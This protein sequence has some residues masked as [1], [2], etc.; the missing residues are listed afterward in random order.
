MSDFRGVWIDLFKTDPSD[1]EIAAFQ[2]ARYNMYENNKLSKTD[3][4]GIIIKKMFEIETDND[5]KDLQLEIEEYEQAMLQY[6]QEQ[7]ELRIHF[8]DVW[9]TLFGTDPSDDDFA[10]FQ[11]ARYNMYENTKLSNMEIRFIINKM[12]DRGADDDGYVTEVQTDTDDD[13]DLTDVQSE[14]PVTQFR[15]L[16]LRF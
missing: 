15:S 2:T 12:I 11:T 8:I 14:D 13:G 9:N 10:A 16:R 6:D 1:D 7:Y 5:K 4:E 3:I